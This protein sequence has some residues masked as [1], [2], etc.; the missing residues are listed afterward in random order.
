MKIAILAGL[1]A[2]V[3]TGCASTQM[4]A[5]PRSIIYRGVTKFTI[6]DTTTKAQVYCSQFNRD[7]QMEHDETGDGVVSFICVDR[8]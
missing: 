2:L 1:A 6:E 8:Q 7:A 3:L 4:A 5:T